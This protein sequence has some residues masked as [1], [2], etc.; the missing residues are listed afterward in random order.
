M[1]KAM[2]E[3]SK[4][5]I[6]LWTEGLMP[7]ST[8][9]RL[10]LDGGRPILRDGPFSEAKEMVAGF[11]VVDVPTKAEAIAIARRFLEIAEEGE[12]EITPVFVP[13]ISH[14]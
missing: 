2:E 10:K 8:A 13:N 11:A 4:A 9:T 3:L 14:N 1:A 12:A 7:P 5:G 6:L